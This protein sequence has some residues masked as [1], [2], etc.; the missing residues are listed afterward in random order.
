LLRTVAATPVTTPRDGFVE[1][2]VQKALA[3]P[4]AARVAMVTS[5]CR[6]DR[7]LMR[8]VAARLLAEGDVAFA[9]MAQPPL[10]GPTLDGPAAPAAPRA[11]AAA[12][13]P[14]VGGADGPGTR[15]GPYRL[16]QSLG[17]GGFGTVFLAEQSEP[18]QRQVALKIVKL[19][20]D[21]AQVVARFEQERQALAVMDHPHIA[22][23]FDAGATATGR[24][25]FV[26]ELCRGEPLTSYCDENRLPIDERLALF[27]QV[28][29]AVQHAH[30]KGI[31]HRDLKPSNVLVGSQDGAPHAKV[32]DFGIAKATQPLTDRTLHTEARQVVGTLQY[33]SPE[34]AEGSL[35]IDT[36]TDVYALG[37]MLYELLAGSTPFD[38]ETFQ[39]TPS[40]DWQRL[41][42]DVEPQRPSMRITQSKAALPT[43]AAARRVEQHVLFSLVRGELDW[44]A[45]KAIEKDRAR[46]YATANDL[47]ADV[48]RFRRGEAVDAAPPSTSY[49]LRKLLRRHR[50]PVIAA[51][52]VFVALLAGIA[53]TLWGLFEAKEQQWLAGQREQAEK[54]QRERADGERDRALRY[55]NQALDALRATTGEDVEK[56]IGSRTELTSR[57]RTYLETIAQ[58]WLAFAQQAGADV[59]SRELR[60]EG[61]A[62]IADLRER[63]GRDEEVR[64]GL[65][66]SLAAWRGLHE[67]FP[68]QPR[69]QHEL[70]LV[71]MRL[72][73]AHAAF[74][75]DASALA[76]LLA[77]REHAEALA[78]RA[79][80]NTE[81]GA[82][83]ATTR[84]ALGVRYRR[85]GQLSAAR[86]EL[87]RARDVQRALA[88]TRPGEAYHRIALAHTRD[89][90]GAVLRDLGE[91]ELAL[92]ELAATSEL[93]RELS[94][95][96]PDDTDLRVAFANALQNFATVLDEVGQKER[97]RVEYRA[98]IVELERVVADFP[99]VPE[100]QHVLARTRTKL[101][102]L[103]ADL[104]ETAAAKAEYD[105]ALARHT[106]LVDRFPGV[107]QYEDELARTEYRLGMHAAAIG[108]AEEALLRLAAARD[109]YL[110]LA[111]AHADV[112]AHLQS[113]ADALNQLGIVLVGLQRPD[114]AERELVAGRE[115]AE[116]LV[117][118]RPGNDAYDSA[119]GNVRNTLGLL[120]KQQGR[121]EDALRELEAARDARL[122]VASR[123]PL[124]PRLQT[125]LGGSHCNVGNLVLMTDPAA[126]L[127]SFTAAVAVLQPVHEREPR[128]GVAR[129]FLR[130]A[131]LGAGR[132]H[133]ALQQ[134]QEATAAWERCTALCDANERAWPAMQQALA[135]AR[136]DADAA[137]AA[138]DALIAGSTG[139]NAQVFLA[140]VCALAASRVPARQPD[141]ADRAID[142][143][144]TAIANGYADAAGLADDP[145]FAA[146]RDRD[147]FR[148]LTAARR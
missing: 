110:R 56:L 34:Q 2:L 7:E 121:R 117:A 22:K 33:M 125:M 130:N 40:N 37:V 63:F 124:V 140:R 50:G 39:S 24:P 98:A 85:M 1:R 138:A 143:L 129:L 119:L 111:D 104:G 71:G 54:R 76:E 120:Y 8:D 141:L 14:R 26:M 65:Q 23:V 134:W 94:Q 115:R 101:G 113:L 57:E 77:A 102:S 112:P 89:T 82:T 128:D 108:S 96:L 90:L 91:V 123:N 100:H 147:D 126:S 32:I 67:E 13:A 47:A 15:I 44:I 148:A 80:E 146:L 95:R 46:R 12:R 11:A 51:T 35:D 144:R 45:M 87:E 52:I 81:H 72:A 36:R 145:D 122:R 27:E 105:A 18:V 5:K 21:T 133:T 83:V 62:R 61:L 114:D 137:L 74:G 49:R 136:T 139:A 116:R 59:E 66:E 25:F 142:A 103:L 31:I 78:R 6:D 84:A 106:Q 64:R 99:A 48:A 79:P 127:P 53:G 107:P 131:W 29:H 70:V 69:Y 58:R 19:G 97:A 28:C 75:D 60:A 135:L 38:R 55:R 109:R 3:L 17:E 30:G 88:E 41:I 118:E 93:H 16:L 10:D 20:M 43:L 73:G 86:S 9:A 68:E 42:R 4:P 132:A 92:V